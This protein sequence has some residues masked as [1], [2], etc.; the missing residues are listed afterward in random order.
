MNITNL[1]TDTATLEEIGKRLAQSRIAK[2]L[3]QAELAEQAGISKRTVER[4]ESGMS[5]QLT[6]LI[7]V[8]RVLGILSS[9]DTAL[10]M[11]EQRPMDLLK[12]KGRERKRVSKRGVSDTPA[13]W[14]WEDEQ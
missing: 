11:I 5:S 8:L 10:P 7:R 14:K 6:N 1:S 4:I 3:T 2:S 13:D 12:L 9:L